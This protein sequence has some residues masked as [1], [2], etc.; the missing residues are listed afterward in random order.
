EVRALA[1]Q[2]AAKPPVATAYAKQAARAALQLDLKSGLDLE[3]DLFALLAPM[4]DVKEAALA[5][6][7]KR[8]PKFS[9]L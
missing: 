3:L 6:R 9:G 1:Q 4:H 2:I 5:F 8:T 7:E